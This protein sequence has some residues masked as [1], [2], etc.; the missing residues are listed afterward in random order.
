MCLR[1]SR[2]SFVDISDSCSK[3][4]LIQDFQQHQ[5][6]T[7]K[8]KPKVNIN[9]RKF[10]VMYDF[11][12]VFFLSAVSSTRW[13]RLRPESCLTSAS[14]WGRVGGCVTS[15]PSTWGTP[16]RPSRSCCG[17]TTST[18]TWARASG[19]SW[20]RAAPW[21]SESAQRSAGVSPLLW[22]TLLYVQPR[23]GVSEG[24]IS[25]IG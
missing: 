4:K 2:L 17:P 3:K 19:S 15:S 7:N 22:F 24:T 9:I 14:G 18:T 21:L 25:L 10:V 11:T 12:D 16:P 5:K 13:S 20:L 6:Q 1:S 23:Y 8:H